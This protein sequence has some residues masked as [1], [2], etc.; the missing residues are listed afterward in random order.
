MQSVRRVLAAAALV[1]FGMSVAHAVDQTI[2]GDTLQVK[3]PSTPAKRK[4]VAKAKEKASSNTIVGDPT[5][6]GAAL[7]VRANGGT[8]SSQ[9]F[10]LPVGT[11]PTTG[12]PF[13]SGDSVKG[14]KYKDP[15]LANGAVKV[16]SIKK[17]PSG[18]FLIKAVIQ[19]KGSEAITVVP[20]NPTASYATNFALGAGDSYCSGSGSA[21]PQPNDDKTFKVVNDSVPVACGVAACSPSGAFLD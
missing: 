7:T 18:V 20:G 15:T 9:T 11:S 8:P 19:G 4:V 10:N 13:W 1:G 21:T 2:L 5:V 16:A 12:K 3:N 14:F 17:T 6:G